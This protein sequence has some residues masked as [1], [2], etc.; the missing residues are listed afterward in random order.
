MSNIDYEEEINEFHR[1]IEK[2]YENRNAELTNIYQTFFAYDVPVINPNQHKL[3]FWQKVKRFKLKWPKFYYFYK[4]KQ[5]IA[6][7]LSNVRE[8]KVTKDVFEERKLKCLSCPSLLKTKTDKI[9][10]C[11]SCGCGANPRA[12]LS[13][14][15][16][17]AGSECPLKKW[18]KSEFTQFSWWNTV[19]SAIGICVTVWYNVSRLW[20]RN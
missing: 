13:V 14:K 20:K 11:N 16:T 18:G 6:F 5:Y 12:R 8:G 10:I 19:D 15:L 17:V 3:S 7:E 4:V 1:S 2:D 9:G